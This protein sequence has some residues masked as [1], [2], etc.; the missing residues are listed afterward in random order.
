[1]DNLTFTKI[2]EAIE[3]YNNIAIAVPANPLMDEMAAALGLYLSLSV[4]GK[5]ISVA[6]PTT[7]LVEVSNLVGIDKV[8]NTLGGGTGDLV[9]SFPYREG[10]IEKVS[11]TRDDNFL[12][13]VVKAGEL[14][15]NFDEQDV[16]YTRGG[17]S[18]ELLFVIGAERVTDLGNLY[19]V[20]NLKD[21]VVVNID[22]KAQN[23]GYGDILMVSN[24][25]SSISEAVANLIVS[26][27]YRLDV[28]SAQN[29]ILGIASATNNFQNPNTSSLAF[30]M[31][32]ILMRAGAQR[33][34][35]GVLNQR[36]A[37]RQDEFIK[38]TE[39][40]IRTEEI[41]RKENIT[42]T[43]KSSPPDDWLEP[44]IYKGSTNF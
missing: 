17:A 43:T 18:P 21:T 13:I 23:Q 14:G 9:V 12:N 35:Q 44:K 39:N 38:Q 20:N 8:Q 15:L 22:N 3:K 16:R 26:L 10:E 5:N 36:Q 31:A 28:D 25:L 4:L 19:D 30:E 6:S 42:Q 24:K 40:Q 29:L 27:N 37:P 32:G 11:Y 2:R 33:P 34:T 7:P 1:M 41:E